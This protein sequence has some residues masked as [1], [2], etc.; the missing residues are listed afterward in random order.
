MCSMPTLN[1]SGLHDLLDNSTILTTM[2]EV[3][4]FQNHKLLRSHFC[5][6]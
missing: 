3:S 6:T 2:E 4:A 5:A 1:I